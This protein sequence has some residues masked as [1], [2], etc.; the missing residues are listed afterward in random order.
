MGQPDSFQTAVVGVV[1]PVPPVAGRLGRKGRHP[2]GQLGQREGVP[3]GKP[4][5]GRRPLFHA[6]KFH[7]FHTRLLPFHDPLMTLRTPFLPLKSVPLANSDTAQT[8]LQR[9]RP[10]PQKYQAK[11][12]VPWGSR[13]KYFPVEDRG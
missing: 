12:L 10:F 9:T 13:G 6:D 11:E 2:K 1:E 8:P 7:F 4:P 3:T 5:G